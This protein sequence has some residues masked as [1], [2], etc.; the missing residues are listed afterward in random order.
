[1][2]LIPLTLYE[3]QNMAYGQNKIITLNN[4]RSQSQNYGN[5]NKGNDF[6]RNKRH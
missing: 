5:K 2:K 6:P 4:K 3:N 1:M